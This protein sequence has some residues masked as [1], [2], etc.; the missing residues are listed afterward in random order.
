M[1]TLSPLRRLILVVGGLLSL[2][3]I[4][5]ATLSLVDWMGRTSYE[6][7]TVF[8]TEG[9]R[10]IV[11][12]SGDIAVNASDDGRVHVHVRVQYGLYK[13]RLVEQSTSDGVTLESNC[14]GWVGFNGCRVDYSVSVPPSFAVTVVASTGDV[15]ATGLSGPVQLT[16]SAGDVQVSRMTGELRLRTSAGDVHGNELRSPQVDARTSAGDVTLAFSTAP[17][18]VAAQTSAGDV[19]IAV[20]RGDLY[21]VSAG[22]RAG[23]ENVDSSLQSADST[24]SITVT[25]S[26]GDVTV[27]RTAA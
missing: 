26:A 21:R 6:R 18:R 19:D 27:R 4:T 10:L 24:R 2:G 22:S 25:T 16:T 3:V 15:S 23:S 1:G 20:P 5:M 7:D 8:A 13:P 17:D 12:N 9:Q 14:R 11:R